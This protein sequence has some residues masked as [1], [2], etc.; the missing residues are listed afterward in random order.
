MLRGVVSLLAN[1][2]SRQ[3]SKTG[4]PHLCAVIYGESDM[5]SRE[6]KIDKGKV[7]SMSFI[8]PTSFDQD[9]TNRRARRLK[10]MV[11]LDDESLVEVS[12]LPMLA[13]VEWIIKF[14]G[15][16]DEIYRL[17]P[18]MLQALTQGTLNFTANVKAGKT[19]FPVNVVVSSDSK[20]IEMPV[21]EQDDTPSDPQLTYNLKMSNIFSLL[22]EREIPRILTLTHE[23][24][25]PVVDGDGNMLLPDGQVITP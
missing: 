1:Q 17:S 10:N 20:T 11:E 5:A 19:S 12:L 9:E 23:T 21:I 14:Y 6:T 24:L 18:L 7:K 8:K 22:G 15:G 2:I 16:V 3:M 25:V 4:T 13:N